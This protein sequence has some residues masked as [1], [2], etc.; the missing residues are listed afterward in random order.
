MSVSPAVSPAG[1][2]GFRLL[3]PLE[4]ELDGTPLSLG[5]QKQ[6]ALLALLLVHA[7]E[8]MATDRLVDLLWGERPP[9]TATT[10]LQNLVA[11]LRKVLPPD[12]LVTRPPGYVLQV[13]EDQVDV[14]RFERIVRDARG[15]GAEQRAALLREALALWRGPPLVDFSFESFAQGE[16]HR[17]EELRLDVVEERVAAELELGEGAALVPE[18]E[19]L[20]A[21]HPLRERF[22]GQLMLALYRG[23]R[24]AEAL[25]SYHDARRV[26]VDEL[27]IEPGP[28][29]QDLYR[30]ILRQEGTLERRTPAR[31]ADDHFADVAKALLGGRLVTVLGPQVTEALAPDA[32]LPAPDEIASHLASVFGCPTEHVRDLAHVAEYVAVAK[33]AGP[34]YDE[35][36]VL[37]DHDCRPGPVHAA[38]A[39][40]ARTLREL[41]A[42]R[43]LLLTTNFDQLVEQA[44]RDAGERLDV[45]LYLAL[46]QYRG[47]FLHV[48]ADGRTTVVDLPNAY[49][50]VSLDDTNVLFKIHGGIDRGPERAWDSFVVSEDDYIDYLAQAEISVVIPVTLAARLRRSHFLFLGYPL[51]EWGLRV[52]LH[53]LFGR[54]K[55]AYR[56]WAVAS[57]SD[58][59]DH[60]LWRQRGVDVF[61]VPVDEYLARLRER[62]EAAAP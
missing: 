17:L 50:G 10:S 33:G 39:G 2:L 18:L 62:V 19:A 1:V 41:G 40:L 51:Q 8:V 32:G 20:V 44:F 60:D 31:H 12:V 58:E 11:Q 34:L 4:A 48:A 23:G 21:Q 52:F 27:G 56:S 5:G 37:F 43:Q 29:L 26:L 36:H 61:D 14:D 28:T 49:T 38:V 9:R 47:K 16:I 7:G 30:A 24:Q 3:G 15:Q 42:P 25:Q 57:G 6:R 13:G 46:G 59:I 35:L 54:E 45:V 22:R 55:V 53:R